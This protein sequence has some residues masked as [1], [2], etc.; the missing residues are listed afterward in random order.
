MANIR[1]VAKLANVS[2]STVSRVLSEDATFSVS[3]ETREAVFNAV[4]ELGYVPYLK[5][6]GIKKN[7]SAA[8]K[9]GCVFSSMYGNEQIDPINN[10][11]MDLTE[12]YL[13]KYN[14]E[15]SFVVSEEEIASEN[16][17]Q[18]FSENPPDGIIFMV[19][20]KKEIYKKII[21]VVPCRVAIDSYYPDT[22]NVTFN[23]ERTME[24]A[25]EY[26]LDNS[27][28]QIAYIGGPGVY[29][30]DLL[31]S[32]RYLGFKNTLERNNLYDPSYSRNCYWLVENCYIQTKEL[33]E[34]PVR[35]NAIIC[36]T[37][38]IV[39]SAYR[40]IYEEGLKIPEDIMV[41][42]GTELPISEYITPKLTTFRIPFDL[43]VEHAVNLLIKRING[44]SGPPVEI[45]Y[46]TQLI[47]RESTKI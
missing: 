24:S 9:I 26:L 30:G 25:V 19:R 12:K 42:S 38:N 34:L 37:D 3:S 41:L 33:L 46:P 29:E 10:K 27:R 16:F 18:N 11:Q 44:Y 28:R 2:A 6:Q 40:A 8:L 13:Q 43:I 20:C 22:D 1:E 5:R 32:R 36:G 23:K 21:K 17:F 4:Q 45:L 31:T 47:V 7:H 15:I 39:F 14:A 35:P